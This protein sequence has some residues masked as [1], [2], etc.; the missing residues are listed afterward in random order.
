MRRGA[1]GEKMAGGH[2]V[3]GGPH[4]VEVGAHGVVDQKM[5]RGEG[6]HA[7]LDGKAGAGLHADGDEDRVDGHVLLGVHDAD[8]ALALAGPEALDLVADVHLDALAAHEVL[9]AVRDVRVHLRQQAGALLEQVD[10]GATLAE[11]LRHFE[12]DGTAAHHADLL[13]LGRVDVLHQPDSVLQVAQGEDALQ[14]RA[15]ERVGRRGAG[16]DAQLVV[17]Q[18]VTLAVGL[19]T[20]LLGVRVEAQG[21]RPGAHVE[22]A[23]LRAVQA[24][25]LQLFRFLHG[26]LDE[27]RDAA[28]GVG[29]VRAGLQHGDLQVRGAPLGLGGAAQSGPVAADHHEG[30][31]AAASRPPALNATAP[32]R[33]P[34][35]A[36]GARR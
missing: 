12:A 33:T 24:Q 35:D 10:L 8:V 15:L 19:D 28:T 6:V 11:R 7:G 21:L 23:L 36:L 32:G 3:A 27:V 31:H 22:T 1:A 17:V 34:G 2:A 25:D 26:A 4:V 16:G 5:P 13:R 29:D 14:A 18:R 20:D 9:E 30:G